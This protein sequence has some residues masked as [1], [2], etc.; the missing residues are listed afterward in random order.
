MILIW[1][2]V[3]STHK[4]KYVFHSQSIHGDTEP[5]VSGKVAQQ[6]GDN[7]SSI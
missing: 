1:F 5:P 4:L 7:V 2:K 3:K 6:S